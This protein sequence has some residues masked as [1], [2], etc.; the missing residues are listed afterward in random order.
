MIYIICE[1]N[2][3]QKIKRNYH[4]RVMQESLILARLIID[5]LKSTFILTVDWRPSSFIEKL[6]YV[7]HYSAIKFSYKHKVNLI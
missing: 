2:Y 6:T 7:K 3:G 1:E 5:H 4:V